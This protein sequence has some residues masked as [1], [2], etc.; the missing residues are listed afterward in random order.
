MLH[1]CMLGY[2][3]KKNREGELACRSDFPE[4]LVGFKETYEDP[5]DGSRPYLIRPGRV[6]CSVTQGAEYNEALKS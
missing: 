3:L 5:L 4:A 6:A 1:N 2:C